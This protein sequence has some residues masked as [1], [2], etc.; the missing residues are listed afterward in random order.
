MFRHAIRAGGSAALLFCVTS[1]LWAQVVDYPAEY[2]RGTISAVPGVQGR[3]IVADTA[4]FFTHLN[5]KP[6]W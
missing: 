6:M 4:L 5:G 1:R 3:L 2:Y